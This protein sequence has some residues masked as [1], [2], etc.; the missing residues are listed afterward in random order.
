MTR[1][2]EVITPLPTP[3]L[4]LKGDF[5]FREASPG[6]TAVLFYGRSSFSSGFLFETLLTVLGV[7]KVPSSVPFANF[8][9]SFLRATATLILCLTASISTKMIDIHQEKQ[10]KK[11]E[12]DGFGEKFT[13]DDGSIRLISELQ[14]SVQD[15]HNTNEKC[16]G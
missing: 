12:T 3:W 15:P 8:A 5:L 11:N 2:E 9:S 14:A 1:L 16:Q 10:T 6:V 13:Y 7:D 4:G